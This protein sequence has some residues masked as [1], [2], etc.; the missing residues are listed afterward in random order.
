MN[1]LSTLRSRQCLGAVLAT[2]VLAFMTTSVHAQ[3]ERK[4]VVGSPAPAAKF[5]GTKLIS[6]TPAPSAFEK[7]KTYVVEFW[8]TWC[9]PCL[10]SIPHLNDLSQQLKRKGVQFIGVSDES[11]DKITPFVKKKGDGMSYTV[12][13]DPDSKYSKAYMSP[14]GQKGIPCAFIVGPT[15]R[16]A[17]IGHPMDPEFDRVLFQCADGK[18][19][20]ELQK[21][22][23]PMLDA[24]NHSIST[25]D[26]RQA[27]RQLDK[28]LEIDSWIFSD[29][30][31]RKYRLMH[32]SEK[33]PEAA[34]A[35]LVEQ[36]A[37]YNDKPDV[38]EDIMKLILMDGELPKGNTDIAEQCVKL[39]AMNKGASH[40]DTKELMALYFYHTGDIDQAVQNQYDAWMAVD[41]DYKD[42][43]KRVLDKY[44]GEQSKGKGRRRGGRR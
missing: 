34:D 23:Q 10:K 26:W 17:Y 4:L 44:K 21:A 42:D 30:M 5:P 38:L 35:Y 12:I 3:R 37:F 27:H 25:R 32:T 36:V 33:Q 15:G 41:V 9:G 18:F 11:A 31:I 40:P 6:G 39:Y 20:P 7:G 29:Q 16:I 43:V 19:D 22:A 8:A 24:A 28:V 2:L 14:A 13:S 1:R